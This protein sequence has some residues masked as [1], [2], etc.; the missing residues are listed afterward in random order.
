MAFTNTT[1]STTGDDG[2]GGKGGGR[3]TS[4]EQ[5]GGFIF[6]HTNSREFIV[7]EGTII[8]TAELEP[9][10]YSDTP[11]FP[12][13]RVGS[14]GTV[15]SCRPRNGRGQSR[16]PWRQLKT[17]P[18]NRK[19]WG[20]RYRAVCIDGQV[21]AVHKLVLTAFAGPRPDGMEARHLDG[22]PANNRLSNLCWGTP[23]ENAA[24]RMRHGTETFGSR[25]SQ[26]RLTDADVI[27]IRQLGERDIPDT[28]IAAI[29]EIGDSTVHDILARNSWRHIPPADELS[30]LLR[31]SYLARSNIEPL[32]RT[33]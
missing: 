16:S 32:R 31:A 9:I 4:A 33:E 1:C 26:A 28:K 27:A 14:D 6:L 2:R 5:S 7:S 22:D 29:F 3:N 12:G 18:L 30:S 24:D 15:W 19:K 23:L 20:R 8:T 13:Y 10:V 11:G 21:V 17:R 25:N